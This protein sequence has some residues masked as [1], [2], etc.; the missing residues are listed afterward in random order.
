MKKGPIDLNGK[1]ED[2]Y[3]SGNTCRAKWRKCYTMW[4]LIGYRC[5][6]LNEI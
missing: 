1:L 6:E 4:F 5:F 3:A 2:Y